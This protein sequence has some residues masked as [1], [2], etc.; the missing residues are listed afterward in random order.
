MENSQL[1]IWIIDDCYRGPQI[2]YYLLKGGWPVY[3]SDSLRSAME[4]ARTGKLTKLSIPEEIERV[5]PEFRPHK[6]VAT[7]WQREDDRLTLKKERLPL[8]P[9]NE[10][11]LLLFHTGTEA[12][13]GAEK[14]SL[15]LRE[16]LK[17]NR[18]GAQ[19]V[20]RFIKDRDIALTPLAYSV[21][22]FSYGSLENARKWGFKGVFD[23]PK[24]YEALEEERISLAKLEEV[25]KRALKET[26]RGQF[27]QITTNYEGNVLEIKHPLREELV[28]GERA[29]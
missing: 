2:A 18:K 27:V 26:A 28:R 1:G 7:F 25:L 24:I 23:T 17:W 3:F 4:G 15:S 16:R 6:F 12:L 29:W 14:A 13:R 8:Y 11:S 21:G 9:L 20:L 5:E 10:V 19:D 22:A